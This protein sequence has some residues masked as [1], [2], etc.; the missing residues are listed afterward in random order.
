MYIRRNFAR[1]YTRKDLNV[2]F[3]RDKRIKIQEF[4]DKMKESIGKGEK[5][6]FSF[7][8][9]FGGEHDWSIQPIL[10]VAKRR[11]TR[12]LSPP[13]SPK[14]ECHQEYIVRKSMNYLG[15]GVRESSPWPL[16]NC[17]IYCTFK[18]LR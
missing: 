10:N 14:G 6:I 18:L 7:L 11:I 2:S 9:L 17:L 12:A 4:G 13:A 1:G 3:L 8:R 16:P 15:G 5:M